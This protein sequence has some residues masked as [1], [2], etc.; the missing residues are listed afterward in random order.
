[1]FH[2]HPSLGLAHRAH[3]M[4]LKPLKSLE[5]QLGEEKTVHYLILGP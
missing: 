2:Q 4:F 1:M 5:W 3:T